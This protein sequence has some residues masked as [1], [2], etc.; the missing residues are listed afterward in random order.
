MLTYENSSKVHNSGAAVNTARAFAPCVVTGEFNREHWV[1]WIGPTLG[2]LL[3]NI[4]C[5]HSPIRAL[6]DLL[7]IRSDKLVVNFDQRL[8]KTNGKVLSSDVVAEQ[9]TGTT[10]NDLNVNK[11]NLTNEQIENGKLT[12]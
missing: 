1:Y 11:V 4:L 5:T 2:A 9:A 12:V 10:A 3:T 7:T 8:F 6:N